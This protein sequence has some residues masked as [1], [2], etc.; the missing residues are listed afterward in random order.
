MDFNLDL[1]N[2]LC[3]SHFSHCCDKIPGG[4]N[5]LKKEV[6]LVASVSG[7]GPSWC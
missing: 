4:K 7:Y 2:E 1:S 5:N 3:F 6:F